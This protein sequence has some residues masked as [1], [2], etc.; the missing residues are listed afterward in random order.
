MKL[1]PHPDVIARRLGR[2]MMLL[3]LG[4][5]HFYELNHSGGRLW[6]LIAAG[7]SRTAVAQQLLQEFDVHSEQLDSEIDGL[8]NELLAAQLLVSSH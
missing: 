4:T 8:I 7:H 6:E 3:H 2:E 1:E 5:N